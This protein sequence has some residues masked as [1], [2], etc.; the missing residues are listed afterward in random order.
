[1]RELGGLPSQALP[2]ADQVQA[3]VQRGQLDPRGPGLRGDARRRRR[4]A[5]LH[6]LLGPGCVRAHREP[7]R[8][9]RMA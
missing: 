8:V 9:L 6:R 4:G 3:P 7:Q 1:M 2:Q 5:Q